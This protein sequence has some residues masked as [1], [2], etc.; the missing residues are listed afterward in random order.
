MSPKKDPTC[1]DPN[2]GSKVY[3]N[4]SVAE[5]PRLVRAVLPLAYAGTTLVFLAITLYACSGPRGSD[6]FW[7]LGDTITLMADE[8]PLTNT[9]FPGPLLRG[10]FTVEKNYF[11]H[12]TLVSHLVLPF[13]TRLGAYRGWIAFNIVSALT[14]AALIAVGLRRLTTPRVAL[15]GFAVFLLLPVTIWQTGNI[16]QEAAFCMIT[17]LLTV[18]Y[19]IGERSQLRWMILFAV[20]GAAVLCHPLYLPLALILPAVFL[21]RQRSVLTTVHYLTAGLALGTVVFFQTVKAE[22]FPS[23]FQPSFTAKI[24]SAIPGGGNMEW[25]FRAELPALTL[26]LVISK[27][28]HALKYQFAL[29]P[30]AVFFWPANAMLLGSALLFRR[31]KEPKIA[32][33]VSATAAFITLFA[34]LVCLHQ[35]QFRY[36]LIITPAILMSTAVFAH[37]AFTSARSRQYAAWLLAT[38]LLGFAAIDV[39]LAQRL[40]RDG[41]QAAMTIENIRRQAEGL[42]DDQRIVI[43]AGS[44]SEPLMLAYALRPRPCLILKRG[45]LSRQEIQQLFTSFAP[46]IL[47]CRPNS[48]LPEQATAIRLEWNWPG[49]YREFNAY[50]VGQ[51]GK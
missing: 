18:L 43:E 5:N 45:Y 36:L 7:Y 28:V 19:V 35:N 17:A 30:A 50:E 9:I 24:L 6:Q 14:A 39:A 22:W 26:G 20:S 37:R 47:I 27:V 40:R 25:H 41:T 46:K 2:T 51:A 23:T 13:A 32:P 16:L 4:D 15:I 1:L 38:V 48:D 29:G 12:H 10:E 42:A 8:P 49:Q 34:L 33:L 11:N 31:W 3:V 44:S 21:W